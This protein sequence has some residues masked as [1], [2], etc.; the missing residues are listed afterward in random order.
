MS[1]RRDP[2][3]IKRVAKAYIK[4]N[5]V[6]KALQMIDNNQHSNKVY[7]VKAARW[8][9]DPNF[10]AEV[11]AELDKFDKSIVNDVFCLSNLFTIAEDSG[12]KHSDRINAIM[13]IA[14]I[15]N[16]T[17]EGTVTQQFVFNDVMAQLKQVKAVLDVPASDDNKLDDSSKQEPKQ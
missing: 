6:Y 16:L 11:K 2:L 7:R 9:K 1:A 3:K 17:R 15:L 12:A 10:L 14:K 8:M 13:G 5:S 4:T